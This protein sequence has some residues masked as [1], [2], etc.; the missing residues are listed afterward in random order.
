[1]LQI[2]K[3]SAEMSQTSYGHPVLP[4][5]GG[6]RRHCHLATDMPLQQR[7]QF[8]WSQPPK[9]KPVTQQQQVSLWIITEQINESFC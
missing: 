6:L 4:A 2:A 7:E 1:M 3:I 5:P 9:D 8:C